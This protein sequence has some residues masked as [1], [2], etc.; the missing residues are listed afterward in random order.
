MYFNFLI[1]FDDFDIATGSFEVGGST[2]EDR[3]RDLATVRRGVEEVQKPARQVSR[4]GKVL[5]R[6][7][8]RASGVEF[9]ELLSRPRHN[10]QG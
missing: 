7:L 10:R 9:L 8:A 3:N 1:F 4:Y 2:I 5:R 6:E